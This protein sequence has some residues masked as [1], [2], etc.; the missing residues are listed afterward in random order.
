MA[1]DVKFRQLLQ[2][3]L[4]KTLSRII[5]DKNSKLSNIWK[6]KNEDDFLYGWHLG[7]AD[8]FCL[9]QYFIHYHKTPTKEDLDEI[10]GMLFLHAND[11]RRKLYE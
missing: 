11:F 5:Q 4:E 6:C 8:D 9:N 7:K 3:E 1:L 10:Q 2:N